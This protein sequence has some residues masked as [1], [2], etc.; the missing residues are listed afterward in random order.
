MYQCPV[1]GKG[2]NRRGDAFDTP[3][4]VVAHVNGSHDPDHKGLRG[5]D[6]REDIVEVSD[7]TDSTDQVADSSQDSG[8]FESVHSGDSQAETDQ[9]SKED[10]S[11]SQTTE[12]YQN[13]TSTTSESTSADANS[14]GAVTASSP[15]SQSLKQSRTTTKTTS[16]STS[17]SK[18]RSKPPSSR[19]KP[20]GKSRKSPVGAAASGV[21]KILSLLVSVV[22][23]GVS[24][25]GI[26]KMADN[27]NSSESDPW[28]GI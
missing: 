4:Q 13:T 28:D 8:R 14:G 27:S 24:L 17:K 9:A 18:S 3:D 6:I 2:S 15:N 10:E 21:K 12:G 16:K 11:P 7:N 22:V 25:L 20:R 23:I 26:K 1:C 5:K 19:S